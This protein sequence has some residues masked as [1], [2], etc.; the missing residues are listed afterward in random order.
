MRT[1]L[2]PLVRRTGTRDGRL[3]HADLTLDRYRHHAERRGRS[4]DLTPQEFQ[5]LEVFLRHP[6]RVLTRSELYTAVWGHDF[7]NASNSLGVYV[8]YL[9]RKLEAA[10]EPRV[11]HTVRGVGYVLR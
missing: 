9:R 1:L 5:L 3:R 7:G 11:I 8:G 6:G 4:L 10:G 2:R